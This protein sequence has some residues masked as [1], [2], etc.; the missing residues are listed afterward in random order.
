MF[1]VLALPALS[2]ARVATSRRSIPGFVFAGI[3]LL[4]FVGLRHDVGGDWNNYMVRFLA[5]QHLDYKAALL[6]SDPGYVFLNW[7]MGQWGFEIYAVNFIC[8]AIFLAGLFAFAR[9]QPY[10]WLV[11][12]V[13]FPYLITVVAMG[14]TRQ[15]VAI[16][17]ILMALTALQSRRFIQYL[18][19]IA[20]ATLF[21][22]TALVMIPLGFFL[23][24]RGW[25]IRAVTIITAAY[26]LYDALVAEEV[27]HLWVNYVDESMESQGA[28]I[29]VAMNLVPSL[30]LLWFWRTWKGWFP[31]YW[32]WFWIAAGS[33]L[34][35][36]LVDF[37]T[38][39]VDRIAL[40]FLPI[41]LVVFSRL[42]LF[43]ERRVDPRLVRVGI[44]TGYAAVLFVWLN[45]AAHAFAWIP[46]RNLLF[47]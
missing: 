21:H 5:Y 39:A 40:F 42:P 7:W 44:V 32:F 30:L 35:V 29:R 10:P 24:G 25:V 27:E 34:S 45:Y 8:G 16:G 3:L 19:F 22:R 13:A 15:G 38:T 18:V 36:L 33:V 20:L 4:L 46:Y 14:Y 2:S 37:A 1:L 31:D 47:F 23:F 28:R 9:K 12:A 17:F 41:Q 43:W 11:L 26:V 6:E